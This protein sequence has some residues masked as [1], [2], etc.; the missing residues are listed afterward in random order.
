MPKMK[1][2]LITKDDKGGT[3]ILTT[4]SPTPVLRVDAEGVK[5]DFRPEDMIEEDCTTTAAEVVAGWAITGK[6]TKKEIEAARLF[7]AQWPEGPQII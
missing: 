5:G 7:L 1:G 3:A 6:H 2:I 4:D